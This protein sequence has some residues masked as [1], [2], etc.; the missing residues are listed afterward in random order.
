MVDTASALSDYLTVET[1]QEA[2]QV[3]LVRHRFSGCLFLKKVMSVYN[4]RVYD[5]LYAHPVAHIPRLQDLYEDPEAHTLTVIEE[6]IPGRTLE[7]MIPEQGPLDEA[8]V[9]RCG[10][11]LCRILND[12][13]SFDPP[14]IHRDIKPSNVI[15][16]DSGELYLIDLNAGRL[17]DP[18]KDRDTRLLGTAGFAAPEQYGFGS[19]SPATDLYALGVLMNCLLTGDPAPAAPGQVALQDTPLSLVI[20]KCCALDPKDRYSSAEELMQALNALHGLSASDSLTPTIAG[21]SGKCSHRGSGNPG[22]LRTIKAFCHPGLLRNPGSFPISG[23]SP[24]SRGFP[25]SGNFRHL[26]SL[27]IMGTLLSAGLLFIVARSRNP[28]PLRL[29]SVPAALTTSY[30]GA[31]GSGLTFY[32]DGTADFY[33]KER[34]FCEASCP[35]TC[36][37][38]VLTVTLPRLHCSIRAQISNEDF[39]ELVFASDSRNW[40]K[41]AFV[42]SDTIDPLYHERAFQSYDTNIQTDPDGSRSCLIGNISFSLPEDYCDYPD[43][44]D[45]DSG[46]AILLSA[47]ADDLS[48]AGLVFSLADYEEFD[49]MADFFPGYAK[50]FLAAF[51]EKLQTGEACSEAGPEETAGLSCHK[52]SFSGELKASFLGMTGQRVRGCLAYLGDADTGELIRIMVFETDGT[53]RDPEKTLQDVLRSAQRRK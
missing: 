7:E 52:L 41:E 12:L 18:E 27:L 42:R 43:A 5:L 37:G 33:C 22:L 13:H 50:S 19:S 20:R 35:W 29:P 25:I 49:L 16:A 47:N 2:H 21:S 30:R 6:Y 1:L 32:A 48:V 3:Y 15:L 53:D 17:M 45:S 4:A 9:V 39:S 23:W 28:Q 38:Q 14:I 44:T 24:I 36:D 34:Q 51:L 40:E 26:K 8:S 31:A 46:Q 11:Q 10:L